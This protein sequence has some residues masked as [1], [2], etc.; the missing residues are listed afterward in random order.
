MTMKRQLGG[1]LKKLEIELTSACNAKCPLCMRTK[2][3]NLNINHYTLE[4]IVNIFGD[5][6]LTDISIKFCG[7]L[8]DPIACP[9]LYEITQYFL[10]KN[11]RHIEVSTNGGL[12]SKKFWKE[13]GELSKESKGRLEVYFSIDGIKTNDYRIGVDLKKVW[14]NFYAYREAG[15]RL[16]WQYI[17]FDYN[18]HEVESAKSLAKDLNIRFFTRTAW[19]NEVSEKD[20]N[21]IE[22]QARDRNY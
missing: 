3:D 19:K 22:K 14:D 17:I 21:T 10:Y 4:D 2:I 11:V 16:T 9:E 20:Q 6:D 8:G 7:V 1:R 13:Y 18:K 15:G 12:K 5:V